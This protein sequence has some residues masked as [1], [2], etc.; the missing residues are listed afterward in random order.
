MT[1]NHLEPHKLRGFPVM[2][3]R[4]LGNGKVQKELHH[5]MRFISVQQ[6]VYSPAIRTEFA[7][8]DGREVFNKE[9][10]I[11]GEEALTIKMSDSGN[12]SAKLD[13]HMYT[14]SDVF[15]SYNGMI[16]TYALQGASFL[17]QENY[18]D[19]VRKTFKDQKYSDMASSLASEY[20]GKSFDVLDSTQY[21]QKRFY[22]PQLSPLQLMQLF[23]KRAS[24]GQEG[25]WTVFSSWNQE[26]EKFHFANLANNM[27]KGPVWEFRIGDGARASETIDQEQID[28]AAKSRVTSWSYSNMHNSHDVTHAGYWTRQYDK[29]DMRNRAFYQKEDKGSRTNFLADSPLHT[30]SFMSQYMEP[31]VNPNNRTRFQIVDTAPQRG[32]DATDSLDKSLVSMPILNSLTQKDLVIIT[33]GNLKVKAG[34]VVEVKQAEIHAMDESRSE[35][36]RL[37]GRYLVTSKI[38]TFTNTS[39]HFSKFT[40]SRDSHK[41][42]A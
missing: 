15:T 14:M 25:F 20:L 10:G 33:S 27:Q 12:R 2:T 24:D 23:C 8:A 26:G 17:M 32:I 9:V 13:S 36:K 4:G 3:L 40:L 34:D 29:I 16:N 28:G 31:K 5:L 7:L 42:E 11:Y 21:L 35:S 38:D 37:S 1:V 6:S 30:S 22:C 39:E 19:K 18:R 41:M